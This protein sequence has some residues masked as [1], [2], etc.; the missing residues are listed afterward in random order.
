MHHIQH[1]VNLTNQTLVALFTIL[2]AI[3][4]KLRDAR[5]AKGL[6]IE[7]AAELF[8]VSPVTYSRWEHRHQKPHPSHQQHLMKIFGSRIEEEDNDTEDWDMDV[9]DEYLPPSYWN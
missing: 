3:W 5:K 9:P 1:F 8:E 7:D 6:T 2:L 4:Q